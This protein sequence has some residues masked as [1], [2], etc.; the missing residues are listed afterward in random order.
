MSA[1]VQNKHS[2]RAQG[3]LLQIAQV[4][5]TIIELLTDSKQVSGNFFVSN[6]LPK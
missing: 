4:N 5:S 6:E 3:K 1:E 2:L